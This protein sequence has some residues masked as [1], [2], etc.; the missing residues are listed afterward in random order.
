MLDVDYGKKLM[1]D[2]WE[3]TPTKVRLPETLSSQFFSAS[4]P[5]PMYHDN[6]RRFHR[7]YMR[8]KAVLKRG[9][10]LMATYTTDVSRQGVG[11]LSPVQLLPKERVQLRLATT[12]LNLQLA[13]CQRLDQGCF[14]CGAKFA[15]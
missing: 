3:A 15:L 6:R 12:E 2:L 11:F 5:M 9:T 7:Y 8:G 1:E 14:E 10:S 4:G 13:R